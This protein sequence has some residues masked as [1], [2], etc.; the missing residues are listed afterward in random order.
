MRQAP[1]TWRRPRG[2]RISAPGKFPGNSRE[3]S[4]KFPANSWKSDYAV[5]LFVWAFPGNFPETFFGFPEKKT[6]CHRNILGCVTGIFEK[7]PGGRYKSFREY[8]PRGTLPRPDF[9]Y[10]DFCPTSIQRRCQGDR[11]PPKKISF[12]DESEKK[13]VFEYLPKPSIVQG[14]PKRVIFCGDSKCQQACYD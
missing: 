5:I 14:T 4:R 8:W 10:T 7:P 1:E 12:Q 3:I 9:R 13:W 2:G 6:V 11:C